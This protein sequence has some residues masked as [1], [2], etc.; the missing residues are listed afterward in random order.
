[1]LIHL[2][3]SDQRTSCN[4][5][6]VGAVATILGCGKQVTNHR[7]TAA[8]RPVFP[9]PCPDLMLTFGFAAKSLAACACHSSGS[10][11]RT[12]RKNMTGLSRHK[13]MLSSRNSENAVSS[14]MFLF[15]PCFHYSF[16]PCTNN[17]IA[18][19]FS[20]N[21]LL[22]KSQLRKCFNSLGLL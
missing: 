19:A 21:L 13:G 16:S 5:C 7:N 11:F 1:M 22:F 6:L 20:G 2:E 17:L 4:C 14:I 15:P 3:I 18:L 10:K 9:T 8:S 12:S